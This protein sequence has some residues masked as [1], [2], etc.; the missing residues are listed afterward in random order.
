MPTSIPQ[1]H[2]DLLGA[3]VH[4]VVTTLMADHMPQSSLIW[5]QLDGDDVVF[6]TIKGRQKAINIRERGKGT[7]L[8]VDPNN[9]FRYIE[10]RG[11]LT[12]EAEGTDKAVALIDDLAKTYLGADSFYGTVV[13]AELAGQETRVIC[14]LSPTRVRAYPPQT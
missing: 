3:P 14:R 11:N 9:P 6:S 12:L 10:V 5:C 13:P 2:R 1:S 4:A 7:I 8:S